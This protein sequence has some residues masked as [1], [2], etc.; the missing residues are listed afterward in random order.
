MLGSRFVHNVDMGGIHI[1]AA[2]SHGNPAMHG[3]MNMGVEAAC[4]GAA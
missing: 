3:G 4:H 2:A 1:V